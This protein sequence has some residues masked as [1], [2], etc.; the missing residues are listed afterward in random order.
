MEWQL[1]FKSFDK[2][3]RGSLVR[4]FL[5]TSSTKAST[6]LAELLTL[7]ASHASSLEFVGG[8]TLP[9]AFPSA[10]RILLEDAVTSLQ[11]NQPLA[12]LAADP[13]TRQASLSVVGSIGLKPASLPAAA[14]SSASQGA[15][16]PSKKGRV[17]A[18]LGKPSTAGKTVNLS[19]AATRFTKRCMTFL[20]QRED[21]DLHPYKPPD[22]QP[23]WVMILFLAMCK[24]SSAVGEYESELV[25]KKAKK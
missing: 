16:L 5:I 6:L 13:T 1:S 10:P 8:A 15:P 19:L 23:E 14:T 4:T 21:S 9:P 24:N 3:G 12:L 18:G 20:F 11:N 25:K 17:Q 22:E 7:F 2:S